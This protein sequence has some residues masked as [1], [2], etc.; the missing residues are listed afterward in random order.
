MCIYN[1]SK[2]RFSQLNVC[3]GLALALVADVVVSSTNAWGQALPPTQGMSADGAA[4]TTSGPS[5]TRT[6]SSNA[7]PTAD[8]VNTTTDVGRADSTEPLIAEPSATASRVNV[9]KAEQMAQAAALTPIRPSPLNPLQPAFQLYAEVDL[10]VLG[11]GLVLGTARLFRS[12]KAYCAPQCD[13]KELN[14]FDRSTAG[15]WSPSWSLASDLG[16]YGLAAA[17]AALLIADEGALDALNDSVVIAESALTATALSSVLTLAAGRPRPFMYGEKA[18]LSAR[19]SA[20]AG[21]S[22]VSSHASVSFAIATST[23]IASR[24]LHPTSRVPILIVGTGAAVATFVASARVMAGKHFI[25][26]SIG[27]SIVG[28]A[29]GVLVPSLHGSPVKVIPVV[30]TSQ[31]GIS[32]AGMF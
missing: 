11:L 4:R 30:S 10:P 13:P 15:F 1:S 23:F 2:R 27:G 14:A 32:I 17:S 18:P 21:L 3:G 6:E 20:D 29:V 5:N 22:F 12:Q 24:R 9:Q 31:P 8:P 28:T 25:T 16:M 26:D 7:P 19:E